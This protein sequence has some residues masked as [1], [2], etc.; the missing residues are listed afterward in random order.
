M[1]SIDFR[2]F[3][4]NWIPDFLPIGSV[5]LETSA[6]ALCGPYVMISCRRC[7]AENEPTLRRFSASR[8]VSVGPFYLFFV[9]KDLTYLNV[10]LDVIIAV[11]IATLSDVPWVLAAQTAPLKAQP[12]GEQPGCWLRI[13]GNMLYLV[14]SSWS[15]FAVLNHTQIIFLLLTL[16]FFF[17]RCLFLLF[18]AFLTVFAVVYF[19]DVRS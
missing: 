1:K 16:L 19:S 9:Y 8:L 3:R 6:T 14:W 15:C 11:I 5:W 17:S 4:T 13:C 10:I 7:F 12:S 2:I 18:Y